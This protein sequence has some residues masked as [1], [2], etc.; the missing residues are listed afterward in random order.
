MSDDPVTMTSD[1]RA[2]IVES[3]KAR[4]D[5]LKWKII[6]VAATAAV[7]FGLTKDVTQAPLVLGF[8]PLISA[9]VDVICVH[10]DLRIL[11][12][13]SFL[14][15]HGTESAKE[16]EQ[17]CKDEA[18]SFFLESFALLGATLVFSGLVFVVAWWDM[19]G[20]VPNPNIA[21]PVARFLTAT[22]ILGAA[23][24]FGAMRFR[25]SRMQSLASNETLRRAKLRDA[26]NP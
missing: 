18:G 17:L 9:Y 12:I 25:Q 19:S 23:V 14:R 1:L 26:E 4:I 16:Y 6:L 15:T 22:S 20:M 13:A 2:E 3:E 21:S 7:G 5:F 10:N 8:I 24:S 11:V